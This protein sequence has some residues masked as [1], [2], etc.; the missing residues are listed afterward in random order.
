MTQDN[1]RTREIDGRTYSVL[2]L[3]PDRAIDVATDLQRWLL[4][5]VSELLTVDST[6]D[7]D[8]PKL[9]AAIASGIR[10]FVAGSDKDTT[11]RLIETMMTVTT[12]KDVGRLGGK[13]KVWRVHFQGR[14][15]TMIKVTAFAV[16]ANFSDFF[17]GLAGT[18]ISVIGQAMG[19]G[20]GPSGSHET[21]DGGSGA[22]S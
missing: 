16:E 9:A 19:L 8:D 3:D 15:W 4:P 13:E 22:S 17:E 6:E 12:C 7:D 11:R 10:A 21:S 5:A 18:R 1:P 14:F 20:K 2:M